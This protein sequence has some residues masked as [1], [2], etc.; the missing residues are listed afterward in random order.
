M[1]SSPLHVVVIGGGIGGL[2]LAQGLKQAGVSVAVYERDRDRTD[3]LA[4]YRIHINP[5]AACV[6]AARA[7]GGLRRH[8]R[9]TVRW[10]RLAHRALG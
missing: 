9:P 6:P 5:A 7:L 3:R 1:S 2:C 4:G 8:R 10:L